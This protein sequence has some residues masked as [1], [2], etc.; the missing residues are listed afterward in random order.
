MGAMGR[1]GARG[2]RGP[3]GP[4]GEIGDKGTRGDPGIS[5]YM[6]LMVCLIIRTYV[7]YRYILSELN[8]LR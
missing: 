3:K 8:E 7:H 1:L 4:F 2:P 5:A 6:N